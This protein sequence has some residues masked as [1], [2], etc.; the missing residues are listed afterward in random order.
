MKDS[1]RINK[2]SERI[3]TMELCMREVQT[4]MKYLKENQETM[5]NNQKDLAEKFDSFINSIHKQREE[6][7]QEND[8]RYASKLTQTIV[9]GLVGLI[10]TIIFS[11]LVYLLIK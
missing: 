10:V 11:G 2:H 7:K 1:D 8:N 6:D 4:E 3:N 5:L 9:Y